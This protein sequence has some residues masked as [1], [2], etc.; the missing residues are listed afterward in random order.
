M[1]LGFVLV[2]ITVIGII[3]GI[4]ISLLRRAAANAAQRAR[5]TGQMLDLVD[6]HPLRQYTAKDLADEL[7]ITFDQ[8]QQ[9]ITSLPGNSNRYRT[10]ADGS[11]RH[12]EANWF[13]PL[14]E[15]LADEIL[16]HARTRRHYRFTDIQLGAEL[17]NPAGLI[18]AALRNLHV[19]AIDHPLDNALHYQIGRDHRSI[20][21]YG[22]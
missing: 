15:Q 19:R 3:A 5:L 14:I 12:W 8:A 7:G 17:H 1:S 9:L 21:V 22:T 16:A 13:E 11:I 2:V 4:T 10:S 6:K 18:Q 20:I